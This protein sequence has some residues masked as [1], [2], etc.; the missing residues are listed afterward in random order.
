MSDG[1][2]R[3]ATIFV[4]ELRL[5]ARVGVNP[6]ELGAEQPITLDLDVEVA[7]LDRAAE[8]EALRETLDYVAIA[9]TARRVVEQRHY[10]LVESLA[11]AVARAVL[12]RPGAERV[13]VRLEKLAC[14]RHAAAAGVEVVVDREGDDVHP[15]ATAREALRAEE[16]VAIVGGGA[17][18]LSAALWCWRLGHRAVLVESEERLGGQLHLAHR[19]MPDL[20]GLPPLTGPAFAR[21]LLGQFELHHGVWLRARVERVEPAAGSY[22]LRA[23]AA[24]GPLTLRARTVIVATGVRRR[25]LGVPG[26]AELTGRGLLATAAKGTRELAGRRVVVVGGGDAACENALLLAEAGARVTLVH[27]GAELSARGQFRRPVLQHPELERRL[28][29]TVV[30]FEGRERLE[31]VLLHGASGP[32]A[33]PADAALLRIGWRPNNEA[34]PTAWLDERGYLRTDADGRVL[35]A[36]GAYG[37]GD[38]LG[39]DCSSVAN[40]MGRGASA[41]QA[42][43]SYLERLP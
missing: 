3:H 7:E 28:A 13:R 19:P 15:L 24:E 32:E 5:S 26:E 6:A 33:L 4:R 38:I 40:A 17:A 14:L 25:T 23:A 1:P 37:A 22:L 41:A 9:R 35:E 21:R 31:R 11:T 27:R 18:A 12:A 39:P 16:P 34:L 8:T 2:I 36:T 20:L 30:G 10:P 29:T 43:A 42:A